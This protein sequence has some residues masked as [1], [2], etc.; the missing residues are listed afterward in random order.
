MIL[1]FATARQRGNVE[2]LRIGVNRVGKYSCTTRG[3]GVNTSEAAST[4]AKPEKR[5]IFDPIETKFWRG[6]RFMLMYS[7]LLHGS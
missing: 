4:T 6:S 5:R 7:T 1:R 2:T 3:I